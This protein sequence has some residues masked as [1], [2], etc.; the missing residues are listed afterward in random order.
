LLQTSQTE[1]NECN[2]FGARKFEKPQG[3]VASCDG[4]DGTVASNC[5]GDDDTVERNIDADN[6]TIA[7]T[8]KAVRALMSERFVGGQE[9]NG[10]NLIEILTHSRSRRPTSA[11]TTD[12][13]EFL[14]SLKSLWSHLK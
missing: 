13:T 14:R 3:T 8:F 1:D 11:G 7:K 2:N 12:I 10:K 5:D 4:D 9:K 6:G